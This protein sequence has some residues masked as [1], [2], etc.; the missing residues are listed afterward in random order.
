[1]FCVA[2]EKPV[3]TLTK[4]NRDLLIFLKLTEKESSPGGGGEHSLRRQ[5]EDLH[6]AG[7]LLHL[8]FAREERIARVQLGQDAA[9]GTQTE[10]KVVKKQLQKE[11]FAGRGDVETRVVLFLGPKTYPNST[12]RWACRRA[13]RG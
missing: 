12:C 9:C 10:Q 8:V 4:I 5:S 6:D 3:Q 7:Q 2:W 13:D 11:R 1:M